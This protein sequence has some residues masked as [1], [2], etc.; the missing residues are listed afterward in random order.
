MDRF[1]ENYPKCPPSVKLSVDSQ[2]LGHD[3]WTSQYPDETE[4]KSLI[5]CQSIS[6]ILKQ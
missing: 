4:K 3:S 5:K 1:C 6:Y 2:Q